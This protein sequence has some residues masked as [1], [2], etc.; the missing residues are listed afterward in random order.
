[1]KI[2]SLRKILFALSWLVILPAS[3]YAQ[4]TLTGVVRDASGAGVPGVTVEGASPVLI[5]K[6]RSA[7]TDGS[8]QY[9]LADLLPGSYG[10]TFSLTGFSTVKR[11]AVQIG[12]G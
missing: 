7:I 9:R 4:A 12:G 8:G 6:T 11:E 2:N 10:V 5:E 1:M 3:A